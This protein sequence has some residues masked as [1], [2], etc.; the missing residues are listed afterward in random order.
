MAHNVTGTDA[1]ITQLE[2]LSA[3]EKGGSVTPGSSSSTSF[4]QVSTFTPSNGSTDYLLIAQLQTYVDTAAARG[5]VQ[6]QHGGVNLLASNLTNRQL[7]SASQSASVAEWRNNIFVGKITTAA[8]PAAL[9]AHVRVT[10]TGGEAIY[11]QSGG[12]VF[13]LLDWDSFGNPQI[14]EDYGKYAITNTVWSD[15]PQTGTPVT[16]DYTPD[17]AVKHLVI[18]HAL[19]GGGK[20]LRVV[21]CALEIDGDIRSEAR[22]AYTL[23]RPQYDMHSYLYASIEDFADTTEKV[24]KFQG[25]RSGSGVGSLAVYRMS[26]FCGQIEEAGATDRIVASRGILAAK[27]KIAT[28][29]G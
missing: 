9:T 17:D 8:S 13:I 4:T 25:Y 23:S 24:I 29:G 10:S 20:S 1:F 5:E 12:P 26:L 28:C 2:A 18:G 3:D 6:F 16:L 21:H 27:S 22:P 19:I 14:T 15:I 11:Y 7:P